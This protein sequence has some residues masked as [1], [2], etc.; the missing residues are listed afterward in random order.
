MALLQFKC[1]WQLLDCSAIERYM[2]IDTAT[3]A[4]LREMPQS[5]FILGISIL[6]QG[7]Q[8][9]IVYWDC[10]GISSSCQTMDLSPYWPN[11]FLYLERQSHKKLNYWLTSYN[12]EIIVN[13][14]KKITANY[15]CF[16]FS[17]IILDN[18][19][20]MGFEGLFT[21]QYFLP[22]QILWV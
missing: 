7:K 21:S 20:L 18:F 22:S 6:G 15:G 8:D 17:E 12:S 10:S 16:I 9:K 2:Y 19:W 14:L 1:F 11:V 13:W 4:G 3:G 5:I